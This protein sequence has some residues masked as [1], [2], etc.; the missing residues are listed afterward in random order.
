MD[1][2]NRAVAWGAGCCSVVEYKAGNGI[3][4][5]GEFIN[6]RQATLS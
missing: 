5:D 4:T 6:C 2:A 1:L 3:P